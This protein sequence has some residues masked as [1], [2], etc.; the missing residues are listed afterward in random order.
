[1]V[2][3]TWQHWIGG[4]MIIIV[5]VFGASTT[6]ANEIGF[7]IKATIPDNQI[8]SQL[9][10]FD[11]KLEPDSSQQLSVTLT[12]T[13]AQEKKIHL[14]PNR[15]T[16]NQNGSIDYSQEKAVKD[17]SLAIDF[18]ELISEKQL[19]TLGPKEVKEVAFT[20][21]APKNAFKGIVLGGLFVYEDKE[22]NTET[23]AEEAIQITNDFSYIIGVKL[24]S[25]ETEI[26]P[27]FVLKTVKPELK[28]HRTAVVATIQNN[29]PAI[30]RE[31]T[32]VSKITKADSQKEVLSNSKTGIGM[33]PNSSFDFPIGF[34]DQA[35]KP[36]SY[37]LH[38]TLT[39]EDKTWELSRA[40]DIS[41]NEAHEINNKAVNL[42]KS[43]L[44]MILMMILII[45]VC[46][47]ILLVLI[48]KKRNT[49]SPDRLT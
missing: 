8:D 23:K 5:L 12:N 11:L 41:Q 28:N 27:D 43:P 2:R 42:E 36:G 24:R 31:M 49:Q 32:I 45:L 47:I 10:Y 34:Q 39:I 48:L 29:Q 18:N 40:F 26:E 21:H 46:I 19:V 38:L 13:T 20:L 44:V 16:T 22:K 37:H 1:M 17:A 25:N 4:F 35:L 9:T 15:A 33:A 3:N 7:G 6:S 30:V 14:I